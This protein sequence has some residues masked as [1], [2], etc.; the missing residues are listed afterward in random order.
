MPWSGPC[1]SSLPLLECPIEGNGS[2]ASPDADPSAFFHAESWA[3]QYFSQTRRWA[4]VPEENASRARSEAPRSATTQLVTS[5]ITPY[6]WFAGPV[7]SVPSAAT[8]S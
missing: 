5:G 1:G 2:K 7:G 6:S 3:L 8:S 4:E